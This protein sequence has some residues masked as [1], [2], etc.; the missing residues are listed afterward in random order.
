MAAIAFAARFERK[1]NKNKS[2]EKDPEA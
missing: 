1:F 2:D